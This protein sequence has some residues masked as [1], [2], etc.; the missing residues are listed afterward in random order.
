MIIK[1][2]GHTHTEFCPHG[3]GNRA[4]DMIRRAIELGFTHYSFTEHAPLPEDFRDRV[5]EEQR[6]AIRTSNMPSRDTEAYL[7][8]MQRLKERYGKQIHISVGFE[9]D[10]LEGYESWIRTFLAKYGPRTDDGVL[11]IHWLY[12]DGKYHSFDSDFRY[13]ADRLLPALGGYAAFCSAYYRTV[14]ASVKADLGPW[15]PKRIG[16]MS[17]CRKYW[18]EM[19][20]AEGPGGG[21]AELVGQ[22]LD[23]IKARGFELDFNTGGLSQP[24]CAEYYPGETVVREAARRGI[25]LVYGSDAHRVE[26]VGRDYEV[27]AGETGA[28]GR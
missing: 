12:V 6:D 8:E 11:S 15:G 19:E 3:S 13:T 23:A 20:K 18:K 14:L 4:E 21:A 17:L 5:A 25:P 26:Q 1:R 2:D 9:V 22:C 24:L 27:Y 16:H 10:Y 28:R 7:D